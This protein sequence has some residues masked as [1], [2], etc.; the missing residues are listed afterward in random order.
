MN[1]PNPIPQ[2]MFDKA[3]EAFFGTA[4]TSPKSCASST[5]PLDPKDAQDAQ[6]EDGGPIPVEQ[7]VG[8]HTL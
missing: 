4:E 8:S 1:Q 7:L 5:Q 3:R 6:N 2:D